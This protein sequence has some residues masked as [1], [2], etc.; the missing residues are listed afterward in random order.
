[1]DTGSH[2]GR[3]FFLPV[4]YTAPWDD[5]IAECR[6]KTWVSMTLYSVERAHAWISLY[7]GKYIN[8]IC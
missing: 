8:V 5:L 2:T 4:P 3:F 6:C 7:I 1:M